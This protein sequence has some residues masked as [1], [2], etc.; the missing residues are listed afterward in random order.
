MV[1]VASD[2]FSGLSLDLPDVWLPIAQLPYIQ[3]AP[4]RLAAF[5]EA[6]AHVRMWGRVAPGQSAT[7]AEQELKALAA[8]AARRSSA[9]DLE[10]RTARERARRLRDQ[11]LSLEGMAGVVALM[12]A[13]G[14]LILVVACSSLGSLLLARGG[15]RDREIDIRISVGAGRWRLYASTLHRERPARAP[16][17]GSRARRRLRLAPDDDGVDRASSN[18]S[19]PRPT[20]GS[21]ASR[22]V[23]ASSRRCSSDW[24]RRYKR[25]GGISARRSPDSS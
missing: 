5:S 6:G 8:D 25:H 12:S 17:R 2:T 23:R 22:P 11:V 1:G 10:G 9:R 16:R 20:R 24:L 7:A 4:H 18:G 3:N 15:V 19:I 13:L 14:L 21:S